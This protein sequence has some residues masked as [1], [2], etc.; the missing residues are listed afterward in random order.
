MNFWNYKTPLLSHKVSSALNNAS[1]DN[2]IKP[3]RMVEVKEVVQ[4]QENLLE[5]PL[6][7]LLNILQITP[8]RLPS[9]LIAHSMA[10]Q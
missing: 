10:F 5:C 9:I 2:R 4:S 1:N 6:R 8:Q 3:Q 7:S